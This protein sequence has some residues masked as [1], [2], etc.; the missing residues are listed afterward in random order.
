MHNGPM[1]RLYFDANA[2]VPPHPAAVEAA[3]AAMRETWGNPTST[4]RE[5]QRARHAIEEARRSLAEGLGVAPAELVFCASATEALHLLLRGLQPELGE[6]PAAVFPG[7]HSACLNPLK[8][9]SRVAWL[10]EVPKGCRTVVQMAANNETG[11][12]YAMPEVPGAVRIQDAV[13]A[14]GKVPLDLSAC[15]A[16]V[17]SGH[18]MG[19][20]RGAALLWMRP[21]LPWTP[22][23]EG[24]QERRRRGGT[25]DTPA[26]LGLAAA[27]AH[28]PDR[29]AANAALA[30][31]RDAFEAEVLSWSPDHA[32]IG[33]DL[34]RLPNTSCLLLRGHSGE[35]VQMA[36]DLEGLAVS[37]GSA[38][39]SGA[40]K[41]SHAVMSLGFLE[42]EARSVIRVSLL[43]GTTEA[44]VARLVAALRKVLRR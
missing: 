2:T 44:Q 34:S 14:W 12:R 30:P 6:E 15:D 10:P 24:P 39:H 1:E 23:M 7:E 8:D 42:A 37:T 16:A 32:V 38:C 25:E 28:L 18:K 26:I 11:I 29:L 13:Q 22:V 17:L 4:H 35:A 33:R 43:P 9:W 27:A 21:G 5:G 41:P 3:M 36:L 19:G 31:L 40:V 20:P